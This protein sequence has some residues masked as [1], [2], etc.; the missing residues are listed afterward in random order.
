MP[1]RRHAGQADSILHLP[2]GLAGLIVAYTDDP[3]AAV[4]LPKLRSRR[5]HVLRITNIMTRGA[6]AAR[7][8]RPI[9]MS[10]GLEH[11]FADAERSGLRLALDASVER[12][13][14]DL[15]LKRKRSVR[16][17]NRERAVFQVRKEP[18]RNDGN[19]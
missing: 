16:D 8:L 7:T 14:D 19:A 5:K 4:L 1:V 10:A 3:F 11:I 18:Y 2:V 6:M 9:H 17:R 12:K 15:L 13:L